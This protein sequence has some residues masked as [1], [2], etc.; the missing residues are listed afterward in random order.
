MC[1]IE[2][3]TLAPPPGGTVKM[4]A[5]KVIADTVGRLK[6]E[7]GGARLMPNAQAGAAPATVGES[8]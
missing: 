4:P 1:L 7:S 2:A 6:R 5:L 8:T 3:H